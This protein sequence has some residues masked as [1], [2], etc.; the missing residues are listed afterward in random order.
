MY[1]RVSGPA[2]DPWAL[3]VTPQ[4]FEE[5]LQV[6]RHL[7][8]PVKIRDIVPPLTRGL[9]G[10]VVALTF[11]D[12]YSDNFYCAKPLLEK[13]DVQATVFLATG[14]LGSTGEFWWDELDRLLLQPGALPSALH[15]EFA[16]GPRAWELGESANYEAAEFE[17]HRRWTADEPP[18]T[19]R[20]EVYRA[21]WQR[22]QRMPAAEQEAVLG[23]IRAWAKVALECRVGNQPMTW[24]EMATMGKC[25]L[26]ELGAHT[27]THPVLS[28]L[29]AERQRE[30][31]WESKR[32]VESVAGCPVRSFAFPYGDS[33]AD[34]ISILQEC[35]LTN[36]C[37]TA[38]APVQEGVDRLRLPRFH[39]S[40]W[41]GEEFE[42]RVSSWFEI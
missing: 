28:S 5:H 27:V 23:Q 12:G 31:I 8:Y 18:P 17:R 16:E 42:R 15:L 10:R 36:A 26:I 20:H 35:G 37:S 2:S 30:E 24:D 7:T 22:M 19:A 11:D 1:H 9:K 29:P 34:T 33:N 40:D 3:S 6:L 14:F 39:V 21:V 25:E 41:N 32:R 38:P 4:H 13:Y